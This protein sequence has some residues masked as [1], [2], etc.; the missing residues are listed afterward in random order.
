MSP[1]ERLAV[2]EERANTQEELLKDISKTVTEMNTTLSK[3]KGFIG[4]VILTVSALW[5]VG[6]AVFSYFKGH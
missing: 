1:E 6:L 3:Q 4:G 5:A 2:L